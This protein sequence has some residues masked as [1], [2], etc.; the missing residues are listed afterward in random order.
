[1]IIR[2]CDRYCETLDDFY[3]Q[4]NRLLECF[5]RSSK[6]DRTQDIEI[7]G[8]DDPIYNEIID[9]NDIDFE[10]LYENI[11]DYWLNYEK[12]FQLNDLDDEYHDSEKK[13][14]IIV[15]KN[16]VNNDTKIDVNIMFNFMEKVI[17]NIN[18]TIKI[19]EQK[20]KYILKTK[21]LNVDNHYSLRV[22]NRFCLN[23]K[24]KNNDELE[25]IIFM[26]DNIN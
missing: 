16:E 18:M 22:E 6:L 20:D 23:Y 26:F 17:H 2:A 7:K 14:D 25:Q 21:D 13:Y 5:D 11:P 8:Y 1:M 12:D 4:F 10:K 3:T 9:I 19:D 15:T 24:I